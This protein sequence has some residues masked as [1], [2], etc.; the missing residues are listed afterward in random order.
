MFFNLLLVEKYQHSFK[1]K[2]SFKSLWLFWCYYSCISNLIL[3]SLE[4]S[5]ESCYYNLFS[6][7]YLFYIYFIVKPVEIWRNFNKNIILFCAHPCI[8]I[9]NIIRLQRISLHYTYFY[10]KIFQ[11]YLIKHVHILLTIL[12]LKDRNQR[13]VNSL[14]W[15]SIF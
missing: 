4:Y 6:I 1:T 7:K 12:I 10:T 9:Q 15:V 2:H 5:P 8:S 3:V 13:L 11:L 14:M